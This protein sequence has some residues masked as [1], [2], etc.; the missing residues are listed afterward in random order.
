MWNRL[1]RWF[2]GGP[3]PLEEPAPEFKWY[4]PGPDNPFG[5]RVLDCRPVTWNLIATTKDPSVAERYTMLRGSDGRDLVDAPIRDSVRI[6]TSLTLPHDGSA[7][8]GIVSKSEAM[9]VKWDIYV[10]G[11]VFLFARSW[12]GELCYRAVASVGPSAIEISEIECPASEADVAASDV[13]FLLGTHAMGRVLPHR[14][15]DSV[16]RDPK[17]VAY[18]SFAQFGRVGCYAAFEDITDIPIHAPNTP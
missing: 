11:S 3:V 2:T 6:H 7:L 16:D 9:E 15:P 17:T 13:Y 8:E 4:E 1:K 14:V 5:I 12:T 10:Y 18:W